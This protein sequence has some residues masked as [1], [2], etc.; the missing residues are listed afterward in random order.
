MFTEIN[1]LYLN[2]PYPLQNRILLRRPH[3]LSLSQPTSNLL[4]T[5]GEKYMPLPVPTTAKVCKTISK[6]GMAARTAAMIE[7]I[8]AGRTDFNNNNNY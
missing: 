5:I 4:A 6:L 8:D 7:E 1:R 3:A 2:Y